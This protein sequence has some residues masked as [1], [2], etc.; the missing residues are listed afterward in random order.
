MNRYE[1]IIIIKP[2]IDEEVKKEKL[3]QY[4]KY[5]KELTNAK[6]EMQDLGKKNLAYDIKGYKQGYFAVFN[7]GCNPEKLS[8]LEN[9][10][11]TDEDIIKSVNIRQEENFEEDED[12]EEDE[13][14]L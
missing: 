7:L 8:E 12:S 13:Q 11:R 2:S 6:V 10:Y 5:I 14:E 1:S 9:K 4:K 3:K